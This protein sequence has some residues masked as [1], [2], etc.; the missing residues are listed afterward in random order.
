EYGFYIDNM[1]VS[2][3][4]GNTGSL[5]GSIYHEN[6]ADWNFDLQ[7]DLENN[8]MLNKTPFS[9]FLPFNTMD[10][11][12][13]LNT[14]YKEGD[15]YFGKA[16]VTGTANIFGYADNIEITVDL[17]TRKGTYINFPMYGAS[18]LEE[19]NGFIS[20]KQKGTTAAATPPP[21]DFT[22]VDLDLNFR[23]TPD[24]KLTITFNEMTGDEITA[25]GSGDIS[26][27]LDNLGELTMDGTY[28]VKDGVYNFAMGVVK[29]PFNIEEGGSIA[30]TGDPYNATLDI[31][32]FCEVNADISQ[33]SPNELQTASQN[34]QNNRND[35][36]IC[37]L[38]LAESLLKPTINFDIKAPRAD[39][40]EKALLARV[41]GEPDELNKQF[42]SLMVL[43]RFQPL[44]GLEGTGMSSVSELAQNQ[45]N[46]MLSQV[47]KDYKMNVN[48]DANEQTGE[49]AYE[50]GVSKGFLDDR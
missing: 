30:W 28:M 39:E 23:V 24:A 11:F 6:Y 7:F 33:I 48:L 49:K 13:I 44:K 10:K 45:I 43:K 32:T 46:A 9:A 38:G 14:Q 25:K 4:E 36:I 5:I 41:T 22:G 50:F 8:V 15:F 3:E 16:Y 40:T 18:E 29:Q 12:L 35:K 2:D 17:Q 26:I 20:F 47:S 19:E 1:P 27:K 21:I 34:G 42:F 31:K 37:Y